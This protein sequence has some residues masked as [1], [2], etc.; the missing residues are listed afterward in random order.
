MNCI[1]LVT[2]F[3]VVFRSLLQ[4]NMCASILLTFH[5]LIETRLLIN[6]SRESNYLQEFRGKWNPKVWKEVIERFAIGMLYVDVSQ[7]LYV[8]KNFTIIHK[9]ILQLKST[10]IDSVLFKG[11]IL[12]QI[13]EYFSGRELADFLFTSVAS[14][15]CRHM[16]AISLDFLFK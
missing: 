13:V 8:I 7:A 6:I 16:H 12:H 9:Y 5:Y 10:I 15:N 3:R 1:Q 11:G 14:L 2:N 4:L